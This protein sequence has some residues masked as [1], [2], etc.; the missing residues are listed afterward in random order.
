MT[1]SN[2]SVVR[3]LR[4]ITLDDGKVFPFRKQ[5]NLWLISSSQTSSKY[6]EEGPESIADERMPRK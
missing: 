6:T 1:N 4:V 2:K 5:S 3:L